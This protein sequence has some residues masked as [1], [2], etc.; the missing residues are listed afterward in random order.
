ML[1]NYDMSKVFFSQDVFFSKLNFFKLYF[2]KL[3]L[4]QTIV[5]GGKCE[6]PD[7]VP[8]QFACL[9]IHGAQKK[10]P[11]GAQKFKRRE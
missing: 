6:C 9:P 10:T 8:P 1:T 2:S 11:N 7:M 4:G 5:E 3:V